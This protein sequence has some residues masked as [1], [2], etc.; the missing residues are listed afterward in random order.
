MATGVSLAGV[1]TAGRL[2][3]RT[4]LGA[5][6]LL[7]AGYG[8]YALGTLLRPP[9]ELAG[10]AL[11]NPPTVGG[12]ELVQEGRGTLTLREAAGDVPVTLVFFGFTR[13]PDVCPFTMAHLARIYTAL[14]EP[15]DV[16]VVLITVDP[17]TD[18]PDVIAAYARGFH[19]DFV[20]LSGSNSQVAVAARSFY[21]GY[22]DLGG[23]QFTHTEVV[24]VIDREGRM[25]YVYGNDRV[26]RLEV[27]L[28]ELIRRL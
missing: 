6:L 11:Q 26:A 14:G 4:L 3:P 27:D 8:A 10:T 23:G 18:T 21:V 15:D 16:Q 17:E 13:C 1:K 12:V 2:R 7:A 24:A 9:P 19:P 20:G 22:A 25:R 5:A 28:P